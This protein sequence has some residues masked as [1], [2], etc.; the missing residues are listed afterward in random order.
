MPTLVFFTR[1]F[2]RH[3]RQHPGR[4][5]ADE[6]GSHFLRKQLITGLLGF[7][8]RWGVVWAFL[9]FAPMYAYGKQPTWP[10]VLLAGVLSAA[11]VMFQ[12]WSINSPK[13]N[14]QTQDENTV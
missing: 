10:H 5:L 7:A 2:V 6:E 12:N 13:R 4:H 14:K 1:I 11:V 8:A 3:A 9:L